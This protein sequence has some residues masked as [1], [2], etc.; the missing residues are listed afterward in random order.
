VTSRLADYSATIVICPDFTHFPAT[1]MR[2]L[3]QFAHTTSTHPPRG[4]SQLTR[5]Y[6]VIITRRVTVSFFQL[7]IRH[8][9]RF[10]SINQLSMTENWRP[11]LLS[12]TPH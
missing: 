3:R 8:S 2:S 1:K 10:C 5:N 7:E 11:S 6:R 9:Y 12:R 4:S